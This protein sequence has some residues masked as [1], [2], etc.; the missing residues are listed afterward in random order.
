MSACRRWS[1]K[2]LE[3]FQ[4][5]QQASLGGNTG[6]SLVEIPG[7]TGFGLCQETIRTAQREREGDGERERESG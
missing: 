3:V 2:K 1:D 6:E 7:L 4:L 5:S